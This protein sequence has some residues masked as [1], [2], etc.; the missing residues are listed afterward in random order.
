MMQ[1]RHWISQPD[2]RRHRA[3][4]APLAF[5][6]VEA[7]DVLVKRISSDVLASVKADPAIQKGDISRI[8][9]LVD[10]K[11]MPNVNFS[12]MTP[13]PSAAPGARPRPS[14]KSSCRTSSRP[15]WCAPTRAH[16]A[17][18]KTRP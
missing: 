17:K 18:S 12:R 13:W 14:S 15:C 8:V 2:H 6:E 9:A 4:P 5:A 7:P 11:I 1:R 3:L 16:W 10:A